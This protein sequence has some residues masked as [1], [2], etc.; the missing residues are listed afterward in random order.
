VSTLRLLLDEHISPELAAGFRTRHPGAIMDSVLVW[1]DGRLAGSEDALLLAQAFAHKWTLVTR[2]E[3]RSIRSIGQILR[4]PAR[5][6][7]ANLEVAQDCI[8]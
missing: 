6:G 7:Q 1:D 3:S 8:G 5:Q 2:L 4:P